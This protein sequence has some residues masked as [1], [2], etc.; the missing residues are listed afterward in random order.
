[1]LDYKRQLRLCRQGFALSIREKI[2]ARRI[3]ALNTKEHCDE[4]KKIPQRMQS[5]YEIAAYFIVPMLL[6][7]AG[8]MP[9][10]ALFLLPV[11]L[12]MLYLLFRRFGAVLPLSCVFFYGLL[13]LLFNYDILTVVYSVTLFFALIGVIISAQVKPYLLC[14]AIAAVAAV[15]GAIVGMGI[16]RLAEGK[17]LGDI[18]EE[19][20]HRESE[21]PFISYLARDY[22]ESIT[23]PPEIGR[24]KPNEK[25]YAQATIEFFGEYVNDEFDGYAPYMCVHFGGLL[26]LVAYFVSAIVNRRTSSPYDVDTTEVE[27][28]LGTRCMGGVGRELTR[29]SDMRFPRAYL[30]AVLLPGFIASLLLDFVGGYEALSSTVMHAFVTMPPAAAFFTLGAF[31]AAQFKEGSKWRAVAYMLLI[32]VAVA[33]VMFS[34]VLFICSLR[35]LCDII[36]NLRFWTDFIRKED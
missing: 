22:Y 30:W 23:V 33:A 27:V 6:V 29:I 5:P 7:A 34:I 16:V 1:M 21:D 26:G 20:V 25:G 35:G 17:P 28:A 12:P 3:A 13:S 11:I 19:Y 4:L 10:V 14:M 18:A 36:L 8:A 32:V 15:V 24:I 9:S 31:F 2:N